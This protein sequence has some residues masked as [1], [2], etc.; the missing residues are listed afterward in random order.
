MEYLT[1]KDN[2]TKMTKLAVI[3]LAAGQGA[4][5]KSKKQKTDT[6]ITNSK[7]VRICYARSECFS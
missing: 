3:L 5:M 1:T 7:R 6:T 2:Q 4:R